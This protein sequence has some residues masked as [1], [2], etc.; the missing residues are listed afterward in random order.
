MQLDAPN[1]DAEVIRSAT[2]L[3]YIEIHDTLGSTN[4]RA[5]ELARQLPAG[6]LPAL[7]VARHQTAGR[8][9]GK[10]TWLSADGALTFSVLIEP[11][12]HGIGTANWPQLSLAMAVAVCDAIWPTGWE[13]V[14]EP[15]AA[16]SSP[17]PQ[18]LVPNPKRIGIKWPN[19]VLMN[20]RKVCGILIESP[21]GA[22]PAKDRLIIGIGINV[23][24][25]FREGDAPPSATALCDETSE[26][27]DLQ[28]VL[29]DVIA[30]LAARISQ[31]R[32]I[33]VGLVQAWHKLDVL[34]GE[35][36][37][38]EANGGCV[39]GRCRG[40]SEDGALVVETTA[41]VQ[42]IHSGSARPAC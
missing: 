29:I 26:R 38:V 3:Q 28:A 24:N 23:N 6:E 35:R 16:E 13:A 9:R 2:L 10:H 18:P 25:S 37:V 22:A 12:M 14:R 17:R 31:L 36:V 30:S 1:F 34:A 5:V 15:P 19:D 40:I 27:H 32:T 33:D 20:G 39:A 8:G 41:G 11:A 42:R 4:D 21:G 7:V